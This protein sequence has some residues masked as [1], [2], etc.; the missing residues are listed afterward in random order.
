MKNHLVLLTSQFPFGKG[1]EFLE[2]ELPYLAQ[3]FDVD[4]VP[5]SPSLNLSQH[6]LV[7][8]NINVRDDINKAITA[9]GANTLQ[10]AAWLLRH[11]PS[12]FIDI[13]A[14]LIY[15]FPRT[16]L[17]IRLIRKVLWATFHAA[18][19]KYTL[20]QNYSPNNTT[21]FYSYWLATGALSLAQWKRSEVN[22]LAIARTHRGDLYT[23]RTADNYLAAQKY[24]I[25][26]LDQTI[27]ISQHG[28]DYLQRH[29][30]ALH[31]KIILSRL[32]VNQVKS[33]NHPS[34][35]GRL[36]LVTCSYLSAVKRI[37]LFIEALRHCSLP[38][39]WTHLGGG[40]LEDALKSKALQLPENIYWE[41]TGLLPNQ[42]ILQFYKKQ[43]VDLFINVSSSEGLPVSIMEAMSHGIPVA[44]TN[45]GGTSELVCHEQ[46]GFLWDEDITPA[47]IVSTLEIF[48]AM[49][50]ERKQALRAAAWQTWYDKVNA[51]KQYTEFTDWLVS[52]SNQ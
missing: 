33:K 50:S 1:E 44:A 46:N 6:R 16:S 3:Y 9:T 13:V 29:Y 18:V 10:R 41:F 22:I 7:P 42:D 51:Q 30:P 17:R 35:G 47:S 15:E 19:I 37:S 40:E 28:V 14:L 4:I 52:L 32:G 48:F 21:L 43:P 39:T 26:H 20:K 45:V 12:A 34:S 24:V 2:T 38:I 8:A 5:L 49:P 27:C 36:H 11:Q 23:N 25:Q 31:N